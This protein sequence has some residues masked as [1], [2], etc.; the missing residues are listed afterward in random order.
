MT[1]GVCPTCGGS[2]QNMT[3]RAKL[4]LQRQTGELLETTVFEADLALLFGSLELG[5]HKDNLDLM[6]HLGYK[7]PMAFQAHIKNNR[8]MNIC[9]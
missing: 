7:L 3:C 6:V 1:D 5:T 4:E 8:V 9:K 2:A